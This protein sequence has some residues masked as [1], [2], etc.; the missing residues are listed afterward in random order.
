MAFGAIAR[1]VMDC[2][3]RDKHGMEFVKTAEFQHF[4]ADVKLKADWW[5]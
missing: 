5:V 3:S 2:K 4:S 1:V